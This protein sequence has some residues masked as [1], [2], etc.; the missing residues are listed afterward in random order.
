MHYPSHRGR[1]SFSSSLRRRMPA[2]RVWGDAGWFDDPAL[3]RLLN[4]YSGGIG[5]M[6]EV[7]AIFFFCARHILCT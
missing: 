1:R 3:P 6:M 2:S 5:S 7:Q 4:R